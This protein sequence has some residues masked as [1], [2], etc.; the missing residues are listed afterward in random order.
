MCGA[1]TSRVENCH[2]FVGVS[3]EDI[4][5][6]FG[7]WQESHPAG[8]MFLNQESSR[9]NPNSPSNR[10]VAAN[11]L[12]ESHRHDKLK[13]GL[14]ANIGMGFTEAWPRGIGVNLV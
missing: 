14:N 9:P 8:D 5:S 13:D 6:T 1:D 4:F 2:K 7:V 10:H 3:R 12:K 11:M